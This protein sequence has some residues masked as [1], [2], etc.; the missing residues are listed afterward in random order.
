MAKL[1]TTIS[2]YLEARSADLR[3]AYYRKRMLSLSKNIEQARQIMMDP[4]YEGLCQKFE[5]DYERPSKHYMRA[6]LDHLKNEKKVLDN[7]QQFLMD[8]KRAWLFDQRDK[9][10]TGPLISLSRAKGN[11]G[12]GYVVYFVDGE[13]QTACP[14]KHCCLHGDEVTCDPS[15][16][17]VRRWEKGEPVKETTTLLPKRGG[18]E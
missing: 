14:I 6:W 7:Q 15:H 16:K 1:K 2:G 4:M 12:N 3:T 13:A 11:A 10:G 18:R 17:F 9:H 5:S 8:K